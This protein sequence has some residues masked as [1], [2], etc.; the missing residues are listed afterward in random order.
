MIGFGTSRFDGSS[1]DHKFLGDYSEGVTPVPIP[2]TEVKPL[3]PD[4]TA[5]ATVW[6]SRTSPGLNRGPDSASRDQGFFSFLN[7]AVGDFHNA[8]VAFPETHRENAQL[9]DR[10]RVDCPGRR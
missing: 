10:Y 4:G 2:N 1:L 5:L 3:S 7:N 8:A 9:R 6:E